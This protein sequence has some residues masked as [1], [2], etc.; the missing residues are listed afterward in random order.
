MRRSSRLLFFPISFC[1]KFSDG[2]VKSFQIG[3]KQ[4][5]MAQH[6]AVIEVPKVCWAPVVLPGTPWVICSC[7]LFWS[8][9]L[10]VLKQE[11]AWCSDTY[12]EVFA[13]FHLLCNV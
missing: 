2:C 1:T 11:H 7:K 9:W 8:T 5:W 10:E 3:K 13:L 4:R 12:V 6:I